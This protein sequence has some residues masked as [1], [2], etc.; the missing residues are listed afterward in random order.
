MFTLKQLAGVQPTTCND[1]TMVQAGVGDTKS[2]IANCHDTYVGNVFTV[3]M[4]A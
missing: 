3:A 4:E 1:M 2:C